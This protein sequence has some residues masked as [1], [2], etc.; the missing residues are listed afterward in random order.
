[1]TAPGKAARQRRIGLVV[2]L[3]FVVVGIITAIS[4]FTGG[5][6]QTEF[7]SSDTVVYSDS[8][9][10]S[11]LS[12]QRFTDTD[13]QQ[14]AQG[15]ARA[16]ELHGM[17]FGWK[18]VDGGTEEF[19]RGSSRGAAVPAD[20]CPRW[21]EVQVFVA[22]GST[23]DDPDAADVRVAGSPDLRP[24]PARADFV[25]LGVTADSLVEDPVTVTGQAAL[26]LPLLLVES[27]ALDAPQVPD[28]APGSATAEPLPPGDGS[29]SSW[30]TWAWLGGLGLVVV[31]AL[32][33]GFAGRAK[34]KST[35]D[36]APPGPPPGPRPGPPNA[37][38]PPGPPNAGPLPG[39]PQ[40]GPFPGPNPQAPP[41]PGW[42]PGPPPPPRP[43]GR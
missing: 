13:A 30:V 25:K 39:P 27:G 8:D 3:L 12:V 33:L 40:R 23:D 31:V 22:T 38:P 21:A 28:E 43:P 26:G 36:G 32:V 5:G 18:L 34:Q 6:A 4:N 20:T 2:L 17:C 35:S 37:G 41:G 11:S 7:T 15:L 24:L 9:I 10:Y 14:L 1:M 42:A 16:E 19:D 29:G